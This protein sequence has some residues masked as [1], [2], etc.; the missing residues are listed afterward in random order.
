MYVC[1]CVNE[2]IRIYVMYVLPDEDAPADEDA[3]VALAPV[4][5]IN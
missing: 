1:I 2:E 5:K 3:P 4:P